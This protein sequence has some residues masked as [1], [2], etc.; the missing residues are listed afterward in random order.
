MWNSYSNLTYE[1]RCD[2]LAKFDSKQDPEQMTNIADDER[3][4]C[5]VMH[6]RLWNEMGGDPPRYE[7]MKQGHEWYEY[8]DI[9]D[10][11]SDAS[12][13]LLEKRRIEKQRFNKD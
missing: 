5:K 2:S 13:K 6:K 12:L 4:I 7:I 1:I 10:L 3:Q 11:T 8:P 9:Y